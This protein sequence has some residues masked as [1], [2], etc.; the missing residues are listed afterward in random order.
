[1]NSSLTTR[2]LYHG[3][4]PSSIAQRRWRS[5]ELLSMRRAAELNLG[6]ILLVLLAT[7]AIVVALMC[8]DSQWAP[9]EF[10]TGP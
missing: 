3:G 8:P 7:L 6:V 9:A 10:L 5:F 2:E 1:V 4:H